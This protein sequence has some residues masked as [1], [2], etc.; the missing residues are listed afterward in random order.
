MLR[1]CVRGRSHPSL[2][3]DTLYNTIAKR[4]RAENNIQQSPRP[5]PQSL[6]CS[7]KAHRRRQLERGLDPDVAIGDR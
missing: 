5:F 1:A 3:L 7:A 4:D 6:A 2:A